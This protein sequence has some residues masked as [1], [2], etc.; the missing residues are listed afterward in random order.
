MQRRKE[1]LMGNWV[2]FA[3]IRAKVSIEAVLRDMYGLA[4]LK[5][6]GDKLVGPCPVHNGDSPRAFHADMKK[7]IWHCFSRCQRGGNVLDLV[8]LKDGISIREAGLKLQE[9]FLGSGE[10]P[11]T[12]AGP[13]PAAPATPAP[14]AKANGAVAERNP[15][16]EIELKLR[17]DHPHLID[18]R[19]LTA[20]TTSHFGVGFCSHGTLRGAIAIPIHDEAGAL[21]AYAG[22][23]L[24]HDEVETFG[25]YKFPKGF[26]K[27]LVLYNLHR[28]SGAGREKGL[29]LV[30]G[31]FAVMAMYQAG[32]DH[33]VASMGCELSDHQVELLAGFPEVVLLFDGDEA[34]CT[35]TAAAREKL[36]GKTR[37]RTIQLRADVKP[38]DLPARA[39]KWLVNGVQLLDLHEVIYRPYPK[40][41]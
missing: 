3:E 35:A 10:P 39:I 20:E 7:N 30:E 38:D 22:R 16:I 2:N 17:G 26:K 27:E 18:V 8:S 19:K 9:R 6:D 31:F 34:G 21:V 37:V 5:P 24:K 14:K 33:V 11:P 32:F 15:A 41:T 40:G 29:V 1:Q 4:N 23:R 36:C 12:R 13:E 25:K 28:A